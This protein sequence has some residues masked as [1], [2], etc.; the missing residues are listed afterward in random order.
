MQPF[1]R[2]PPA[3][4]LISMSKGPV[5][6]KGL[7]QRL[8]QTKAFESAAQEAMLNL[9]VAAAAVR[10]DIDRVCSRHGLSSSQYN[11]LR[12]LAGGPPEGYPRCDIIE[13]MIDRGPDVTRLTDRLVKSGLAERGRSEADG[14]LTMHR[15]TEKGRALLA[16]IH[17]DIQRLQEA[18]AQRLS[19]E[20][21]QQLSALC[22]T[23]YEK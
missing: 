11:V 19:T 2:S 3:A 16:R 21:Q 18:F 14:R 12:I 8:R 20:E 17:P 1:L 7:T 4:L 9:M 5:Q 10:E 13:R 15:I 22:E 23:I 6:S